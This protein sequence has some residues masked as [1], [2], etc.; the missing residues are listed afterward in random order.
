MRDEVTHKILP[1]R[2]IG[3]FVLG[4]PINSIVVDILLGGEGSETN[5]GEGSD[6]AGKKGLDR[7][8]G[9][10]GVSYGGTVNVLERWCSGGLCRMEMPNAGL[11]LY[12][13]I[14]FQ[15]LVGV[16]VYDVSRLSLSL[17]VQNQNRGKQASSG[18][19]TYGDFYNAFGPTIDHPA[20]VERR[21][22]A[23]VYPGMLVLFEWDPEW[24]EGTD[25]LKR[26]QVKEI[27]VMDGRIE[28]VDKVEALRTDV[29]T[30]AMNDASNNDGE[31][32]S[33]GHGAAKAVMDVYR[34]LDGVKE[35]QCVPSC[36]VAVLG[37]G[38]LVVDKSASNKAFS[39][40]EDD[41]V[42]FGDSYQ[43]VL[44]VLGE[45]DGVMNKC[46]QK[47][48]EVV[49]NYFTRGID[50]V[51]DRWRHIVTLIVVH[52]NP[53][54]HAEFGNYYKCFFVHLYSIL[55]FKSIIY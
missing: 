22:K 16:E 7:E 13:C 50:V 14:K 12:F 8:D 47:Q 32:E 11:R 37:M 15:Y 36:V 51:F 18:V 45:P 52:T 6:P 49:W 26:A 25:W 28:A 31:Q 17:G 55:F 29:Y 35:E 46:G 40:P 20:N 34:Q 38:I 48:D 24:G 9:W 1:G 10:K 33:R 53:I 42:R 43:E 41:M 3:P 39:D 2:G 54:A 30:G 27:V 21:E 4:S 44:C 23:L 19:L 5:V